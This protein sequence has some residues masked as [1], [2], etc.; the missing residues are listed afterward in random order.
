MCILPFSLP[1]F[2]THTQTSVMKV[3]YLR[4]KLGK[5]RNLKHVN[6]RLFQSVIIIYQNWKSS[7]CP[8]EF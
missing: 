1:L 2:A 8:L 5:F 7:F 6:D 3:N 4:Q